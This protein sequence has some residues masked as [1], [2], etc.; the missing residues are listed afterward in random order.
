VEYPCKPLAAASGQPRLI[1][2]KETRRSKV[3]IQAGIKALQAKK[4]LVL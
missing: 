1:V 2:R 3:P 4:V